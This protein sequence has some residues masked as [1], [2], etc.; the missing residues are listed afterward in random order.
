MNMFYTVLLIDEISIQ[1]FTL[2]RSDAP[3]PAW[4][5]I[6]SRRAH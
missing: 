4:S 3:G 6:V 2:Q 1:W 5:V